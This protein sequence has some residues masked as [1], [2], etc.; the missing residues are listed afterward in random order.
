MEA[1]QAIKYQHYISVEYL[2]P[3]FIMEFGVPPEFYDTY[4]EETIRTLKSAWDRAKERH[5]S[6]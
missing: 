1:L 5:S 4:A 2:P 6:P 3:R